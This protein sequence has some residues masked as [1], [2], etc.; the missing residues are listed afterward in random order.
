MHIAYG[1][2]LPDGGLVRTDGN[3]R[4]IWSPRQA[5]KLGLGMVHQ[6]FTSIPAL[7]VA[8]NIALAAG[9]AGAPRP[10]CPKAKALSEKIGL[11]LHPG[12]RARRLP[13]GFKETA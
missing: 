8:E 1:M 6:H 11:P 3:D 7:T 10:H 5:R 4:T 12:H 9:W 13:G 2:L